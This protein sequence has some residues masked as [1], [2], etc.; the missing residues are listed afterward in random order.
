[1]MDIETPPV[2]DPYELRPFQ[3]Y[4]CSEGQQV[5]TYLSHALH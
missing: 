5:E 4:M 3:G 1:M 2:L